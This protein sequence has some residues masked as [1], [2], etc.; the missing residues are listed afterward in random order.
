[1]VVFEPNR[2]IE[3]NVSIASSILLFKKLDPNYP[4]A[5]DVPSGGFIIGTIM[6]SVPLSGVEYTVNLGASFRGERKANH[7]ILR[8]DFLPASV[9]RTAEGIFQQ[10]DGNKV[11]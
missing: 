9:D 11:T 8:Y 7:C 10:G 4:E 2:C 1:M 5:V 6:A 3:S